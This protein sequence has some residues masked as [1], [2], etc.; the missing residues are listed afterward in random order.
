MYTSQNYTHHKIGNRS[1]RNLIFLILIILSAITLISF[2]IVIN[3]YA[4]D[5]DN[6]EWIEVQVN[7][8]DTLW[9]LV[10]KHYTGDEDIREIIYEVR[11]L[12]NLKSSAIIPRQWIKIP[13]K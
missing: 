13:I 12:N 6:V 10:N 3:A 1:N 5:V 9:K 8:G 2:G 4:S 11:S 7:Q